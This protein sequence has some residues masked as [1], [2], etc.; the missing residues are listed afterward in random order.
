M[1]NQPGNLA[2]GEEFVPAGEEAAIDR[3]VAI[4]RDVQEVSDR[5]LNPVRRGQ[6]PKQHG[7]VRADF[8]VLPDLPD[9]LRH[10]VFREPRTYRTLIRFSNGRQWDDTKPDVHGMAIKLL[11]VEGEK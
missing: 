10:G 3:I 2:V 5:K 11:E 4:H 6:H 8:I 1:S 9:A 7:C